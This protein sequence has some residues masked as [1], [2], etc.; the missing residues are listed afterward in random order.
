M[1][2]ILLVTLAVFST[3]SMRHRM[4]VTKNFVFA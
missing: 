3:N 4:I 2:A 1:D